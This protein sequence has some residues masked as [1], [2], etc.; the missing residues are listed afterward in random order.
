M[1]GYRHGGHGHGGHGHGGHGYGGHGYGE[2]GYG[3][4]G[5]GGHGYGEHG[6]GGHGYGGPLA[7]DFNH[8]GL[9]TE[10]DFAIGARSMGWGAIG[11]SVARSAFRYYDKNRN[12]YLDVQ[13]AHGAYG[14]LHR[15]YC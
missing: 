11:E 6:Y 8:D 13:D 2:H 10:A 15:L 1:Y 3:G 12:G 14:H 7:R 9:I 4:H 5:Y